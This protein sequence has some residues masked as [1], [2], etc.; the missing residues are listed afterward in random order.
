MPLVA[1]RA[2]VHGH[3]QGVAFRHHTKTLARELGLRGWVRN[4]ENGDVEAWVEGEESAVATILAWL[5]KGPPA[6][7]VTRV[8]VET[9]A[10]AGHAQFKVR[11]D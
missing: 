4:V 7:R 2:L 5:E 9:V 1:R 10:P 8:E 6:A 11:F 3:V